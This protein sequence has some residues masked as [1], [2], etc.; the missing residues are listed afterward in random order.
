MKKKE[1]EKA[2]DR[3]RRA[4]PAVRSAAG[5]LL[6]RPSSGSPSRSGGGVSLRYSFRSVQADE[7]E[8]R[9][10]AHEAR[11]EEGKLETESIEG[12]IDR[13]R[14]LGALRQLQG[15]VV[16]RAAALLG[17][18]TGLLGTREEDGDGEK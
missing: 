1:G 17:P 14:Y 4:L 9:F 18:L 8:V 3:I 13:G 16:E 5:A 12:S 7:R 6:R 2:L 10:T 11:F 15:E